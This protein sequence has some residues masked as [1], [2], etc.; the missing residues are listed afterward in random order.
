MTSSTKQMRPNAK[1]GGASSDNQSI[2]HSST[3]SRIKC[4]NTQ[5]ILRTRK[6]WDK[7]IEQTDHVPWICLPQGDLPTVHS[8]YTHRSSTLPGGPLGVF[9]PSP[10][11]EGAWIH[12]G[13]GRQTSHQPTDA[14]TPVKWYTHYKGDPVE[15]GFLTSRLS[16]SSETT[17]IHHFLLTFH[18]MGLRL[19]VSDINGDFSQKIT[20]FFIP[21]ILRS[22]W[23]GPHCNWVPAV[24]VKKQNGLNLFLQPWSPQ[25]AEQRFLVLEYC[26]Q[27]NDSHLKL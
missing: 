25:G 14:S 16:R 20:I 2:Q 11:T 22:H 1:R 24:G 9:Y 4:D 23:K 5:W 12:F 7:S 10:T 8:R 6:T 18:S 26:L 13:G 3:Y 19:T 27:T 15:N 21:H 17:L